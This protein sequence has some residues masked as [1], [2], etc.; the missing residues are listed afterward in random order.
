MAFTSRPGLGA[1]GW[2]AAPAHWDPRICPPL[3]AAPA[4]SPCQQCCLK[5][6]SPACHPPAG[7]CTAKGQWVPVDSQMMAGAAPQASAESCRLHVPAR[8]QAA[9]GTWPCGPSLHLAAQLCADPWAGVPVPAGLLASS[10][11]ACPTSPSFR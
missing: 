6:A 11:P 3:R 1:G 10:A 7:G 5:V 2:G 4:S 8:S 9:Q